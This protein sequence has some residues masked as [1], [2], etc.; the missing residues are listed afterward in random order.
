MIR[1]IRRRLMSSWNDT[2]RLDGK[3]TQAATRFVIIVYGC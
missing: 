3:K 1:L 2:H